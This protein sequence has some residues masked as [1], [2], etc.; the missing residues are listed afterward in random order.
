VFSGIR[1]V[2]ANSTCPML[3]TVELELP[4]GRHRKDTY[5]CST[6]LR[7]SHRMNWPDS[8]LNEDVL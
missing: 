8:T 7:T 3:K 2:I 4:K 5:L 6:A 1:T